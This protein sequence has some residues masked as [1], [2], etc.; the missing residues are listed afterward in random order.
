MIDNNNNN[1]TLCPP[2]GWFSLQFAV[3]TLADDPATGYVVD[4][5]GHDGKGALP[6]DAPCVAWFGPGQTYPDP[7]AVLAAIQG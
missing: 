6:L 2:V 1:V 7:W 4:L 5:A 3:V